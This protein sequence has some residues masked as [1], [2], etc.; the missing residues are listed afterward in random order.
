MSSS[1]GRDI[2]SQ[3]TPEKAFTSS[4]PSVLPGLVPGIHS[5]T[6]KTPHGCQT[7]RDHTLRTLAVLLG[8]DMAIG[9]TPLGRLKRRVMD[10]RN[11][12]GGSGKMEAFALC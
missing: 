3:E 6:S 11:K 7:W 5:A 1:L 9:P 8:E 2:A 12:S 10:P 4:L